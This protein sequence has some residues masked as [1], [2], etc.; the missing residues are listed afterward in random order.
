MQNAA[1]NQDQADQ[2]QAKPKNI[3]DIARGARIDLP[4]WLCKSLSEHHI[5]F[6]STPNFLNTYALQQVKP[7][8]ETQPLFRSSPYYF[9]IVP[10][11]VQYLRNNEDAIAI[12][13]EE[14]ANNPASEEADRAKSLISFNNN[15]KN[16]TSQALQT[17]MTNAFITRFT[18]ILIASNI[19]LPE[20]TAI[21]E[22]SQRLTLTER[23]LFDLSRR[24]A[25]R[26]ID[27]RRSRSAIPTPKVLQ[28][29]QHSFA[30]TMEDD[31]TH[32][33]DNQRAKRR[34]L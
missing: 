18:K 3:E 2:Q 33:S 17:E 1:A 9:D 19:T 5:I 15:S 22:F 24:A 7:D 6:T 10:T 23:H 31:D 21:S 16:P 20:K 26:L 27:W 14:L 29:M 30:S 12:L 32:L 11:M 8:P 34:A 28:E 4:L 25:E 13:Q